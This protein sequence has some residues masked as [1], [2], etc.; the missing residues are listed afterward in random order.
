MGALLP[1]GPVNHSSSPYHQRQCAIFDGWPECEPS[2]AQS[3]D[4][5]ERTIDST[6]PPRNS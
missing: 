3:V 1:L 2:V 5:S 6:M 4:I